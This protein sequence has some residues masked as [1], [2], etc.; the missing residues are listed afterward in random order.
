MGADR[1][2]PTIRPRTHPAISCGRRD[3]RT[4][5]ATFGRLEGCWYGNDR[6]IYIVSTSGGAAGQGQIWVYIRSRETIAMLFESPSAAV[7]N[8]PDN[9]TVS[10][11]GGLVLC[12]DGGGEEFVHGLTVDGEIF[13]F[14]KNNV[15]AQRASATG[16][17]ATSAD[18]NLRAPATVPMATGCSSTSRVRE[19]P[20]RSPDPG[21]RARCNVRIVGSFGS[22]AVRTTRTLRLGTPIAPSSGPLTHP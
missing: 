19:S 18:R 21:R 1:A 9:I 17:P 12:E 10:P 15:R 4:G 6:K 22:S 20:S 3:A 13:Q 5:A 2:R 8:A 11:R 16:S 14:A 7:L